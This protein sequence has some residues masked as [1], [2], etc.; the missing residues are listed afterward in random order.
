MAKPIFSI[1]LKDKLF[2]LRIVKRTS[3]KTLAVWAIDCTKRVMPFFEDKNPKDNRPRKAIETLREWIQTGVF[4]MALIR[5][6]SLGA[7]AAA[8][9]VGEDSPARSA[10]HAAGQC[11]ATA[12]VPMHSIG[13]ALYAL[14]AIYRDTN[15]I[16]AVDK[17]RVWQYNHLLILRKK[18]K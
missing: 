10:A 3:H 5:K 12:H 1:S 14:Q 17:E 2:F 11:V 16:E 13:S 15:S 18:K 7:H 8:K 6:A 9:D 4:Q